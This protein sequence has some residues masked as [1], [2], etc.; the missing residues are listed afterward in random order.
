MREYMDVDHMLL[1]HDRRIHTH[2]FY[3]QH[4]SSSDHK[5]ILS[6]PIDQSSE[7]MHWDV[8]MN[9][10]VDLLSREE[11]VEMKWLESA[12]FVVQFQTSSL[13][14]MNEMMGSMRRDE[15]LVAMMDTVLMDDMVS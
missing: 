5:C 9:T 8:A 2:I 4:E 14:T 6:H 13:M 12:R 7:Q 3:K 11:H 10:S 1:E 15:G